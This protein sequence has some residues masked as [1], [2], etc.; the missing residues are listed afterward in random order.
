M[1]AGSDLLRPGQKKG[2][3]LSVDGSS[4]TITNSC[5]QKNVTKRMT[6]EETKSK[7][8]KNVFEMRMRKNIPKQKR[9]TVGSVLH[10]HLHLRHGHGEN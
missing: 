6:D 7:T 3:T 1:K 4:K 8:N 2:Q 10:L 5:Q 9:R